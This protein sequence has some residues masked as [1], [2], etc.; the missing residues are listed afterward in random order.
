VVVEIKISIV[1]KTYEKRIV[2]LSTTINHRMDL[3]YGKKAERVDHRQ[4][5]CGFLAG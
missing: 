4:R 5:G 2:F 3:E 1:E